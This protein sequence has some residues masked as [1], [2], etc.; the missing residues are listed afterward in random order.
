M[1]RDPQVN[2]YAADVERS[3]R[4]YIDAFG[5]RETFRT[6][7]EGPPAHVEV[8]LG[9]FVLGIASF[10][11]ARGHGVAAG[12]GAPSA[13]LVLWTDDVDAAQEDAVARG[14]KR[15]SAPH[16]FDILR[17]AWVADPDG[18]PIQLVQR[19]SR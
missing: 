5:F 4:F 10:E 17:G 8:R 15:L 12:A 1:F 16:D 3:V 14:A 2:L 9:E 6:P 19:R 18:H 11:A 7:T 13:E